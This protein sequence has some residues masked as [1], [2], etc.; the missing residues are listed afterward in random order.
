MIAI[1]VTYTIKEDYVDANKENIQIFLDAFKELD[2]HQFVYT[3]FQVNGS[4][5]FIHMSQYKNE[6]I[7][8]ELL[9]MPAFLEFQ[10]QRDLH[11]LSEPTI[12]SLTQI[13]ISKNIW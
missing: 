3:I 6:A 9:N 10:K 5:T 11:L 2:N 8:K 13:G 7:Q 4:N 12:E 1:K